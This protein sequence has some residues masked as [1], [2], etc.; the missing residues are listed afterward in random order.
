MP[1]QSVGHSRLRSRSW[2]R[3]GRSRSAVGA[4]RRLFERA[5]SRRCGL[6]LDRYEGADWGVRPDF[7]C[8]CQWELDAAQALG[9]AE[10]GSVEGVDCV[11]MV[12]VADVADSGV[13]VVAAVGVGTAH[14]ADGDVFEDG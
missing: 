10:A 12:E 13:V 1:T 11:A 4:G 9:G 8:S 2:R 7:G 3:R 5:A 14:R 6:V